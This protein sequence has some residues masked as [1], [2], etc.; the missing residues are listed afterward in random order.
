[1]KLTNSILQTYITKNGIKVEKHPDSKLYLYGYYSGIGSQNIK[2]DEYSI[3]CRGT[4]LDEQN[5]IIARSFPKF[6]HLKNFGCE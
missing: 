2:W 1:M 6:L 3:H 5:N 4:V